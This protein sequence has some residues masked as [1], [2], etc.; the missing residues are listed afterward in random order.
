M[1]RAR[2]FRHHPRDL[3]RIGAE[4]EKKKNGR[5]ESETR[6][7][8]WPA[9]SRAPVAYLKDDFE[10]G[11][12]DRSDKALEVLLSSTPRRTVV[13]FSA[14]ALARPRSRRGLVPTPGAVIFAEL[15]SPRSRSPSLFPHEGA[16]R[17]F[18]YPS[19]FPSSSLFLILSLP[20]SLFLRCSFCFALHHHVRY[21]RWQCASL[22][23][24]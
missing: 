18:P 3:G 6:N 19:R 16:P 15:P 24:C 22:S 4:E 7:R 1:L 13:I 8:L 10:R 21:V 14:R 2:C 11:V 12:T 23:S 5:K 17:P 9:G 20:L